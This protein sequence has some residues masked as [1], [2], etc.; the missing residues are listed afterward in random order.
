MPYFGA[1]STPPTS[2]FDLTVV[3]EVA[4]V[5]LAGTSVL[6]E[7]ATDPP[8]LSPLRATQS[9]PE[10]LADV[11]L[12]FAAWLPPTVLTFSDPG[13]RNIQPH[14]V[15]IDIVPLI[16]MLSDSPSRLHHRSHYLPIPRCHLTCHLC[17]YPHLLDPHLPNHRA[18]QLIPHTLTANDPS[19]PVPPPACSPSLPN[20]PP[21]PSPSMPSPS[22][23]LPARFLLLPDMTPKPLPAHSPPMFM[24]I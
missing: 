5:V 10:P 16:G 12:H 19:P 11:R 15:D 14:R 20:L 17:A 9:S 13:E 23:P 22:T 1:D 24:S 6:S 18:A 2:P 4:S 3:F 8:T 7:V 21:A